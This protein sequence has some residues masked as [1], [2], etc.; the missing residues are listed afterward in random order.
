[1]KLSVSILLA[2]LLM[3][4]FCMAQDD[5]SSSPSHKSIDTGAATALPA[6]DPG[7]EADIRKLLDM[8]GTKAT[9]VRTMGEMIT[10]MRP[11]LM[12]S[13]PP[14]AYREK[15]IT[16]FSEKFQSK[17]DPQQML[18]LAVPIYDKYLSDED[19]RGLM[20]FYSTPLG[21]KAIAVLPKLTSECLQ[22]GEKWGE[23]LGRDSMIEVLSE[24]PDLKR[25]IEESKSMSAQ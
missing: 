22:A 23:Q 19:I 18:D 6:I 9:M 21:Q 13:L 14:G 5:S 10:N 25:A 7:K 4:A 1:M 20:Q 3:S 8:V 2:T 15:L 16:L 17:A 24:N 11:L 12:N